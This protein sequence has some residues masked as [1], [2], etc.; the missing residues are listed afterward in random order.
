MSSATTELKQYLDGALRVT[1]SDGRM[2]I[3]RFACFDKQ[4]NVLLNE[5]REFRTTSCEGRPR[6]LGIVLVPWRWIVRCD[7]E[8]R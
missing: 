5:A 8:R 6:S 2:L 3:G 4:R 7:A 1:L